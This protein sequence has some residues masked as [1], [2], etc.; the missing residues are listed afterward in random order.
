MH[1]LLLHE[2]IITY[3][4]KIMLEIHGYNGKIFL[5]II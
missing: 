1:F 5:N 4:K 3:N 2:F